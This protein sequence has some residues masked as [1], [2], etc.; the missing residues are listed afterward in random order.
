[1]AIVLFCL[2]EMD[3]HEA[4]AA[5]I[6]GFRQ[7]DGERKTDG[8]R[9][10]DRIAAAAEDIDADLG[11]LLLLRRDH[12]VQSTGRRELALGAGPLASEGGKGAKQQKTASANTLLS[13]A[14]DMKAPGQR[15]SD[16]QA[17]KSLSTRP[18]VEVTR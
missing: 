4:A 6:A 2:R 17:I 11:R 7:S 9:G 8:D 13:L 5:E 16:R 10:I 15:R 18:L 12:A 14:L 1:M 3:E